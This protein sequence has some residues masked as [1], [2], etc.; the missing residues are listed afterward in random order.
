MK[1]N[2]LGLI[3]VIVS[4]LAAP[5]M[6]G[7][8]AAGEAKAAGCAA[9]HGADGN[10]AVAIYPKLAGLGE[11]YLAKQLAD[12]KSGERMI[13]E[14]IGQLD[15]MSE[16]DLDDIAAFYAAKSRSINGARE[17]SAEE[18]KAEAVESNAQFMQIGENIFRAGNMQTSVPA[19][20]GCH[21]PTGAGNAPAGYPALGGQHAD[22]IEKQLRAFRA[23]MRVNDGEA[24][25]MQ[26]VAARLTDREIKAVAN[27]IAGLH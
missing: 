26:G 22:Y 11:K 18:L 20:I 14:M 15:N 13:P 27:Y 19:C 6:A 3:A 25:V 17:L 24:K 4:L 2:I 12:I 21:S 16:Q 10:S 7:D 23:N 8:P 1:N 5:A 9:C